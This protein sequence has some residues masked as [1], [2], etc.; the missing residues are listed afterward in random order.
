MVQCSIMFMKTARLT[1]CLAVLLLLLS[2]CG[3]STPA[4]PERSDRDMVRRLWTWLERRRLISVDLRWE[5]DSL[6]GVVHAGVRTIPLVKASFKRDTNDLTMEFDAEGNRGRT[7][8]YVIEGKL[9][10][11]AIS[12]TWTHDDEQGDFKVT[13]Q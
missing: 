13:K 5:N 11:N 3:G 6:H 10:G 8:H 9:S 4:C 7:V 12:G 1:S 2:A